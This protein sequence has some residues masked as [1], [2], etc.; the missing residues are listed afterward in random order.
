MNTYRFK[1]SLRCWHE[2]MAPAEICDLL[3]MEPAIRRRAGQER[4]TPRGNKAGGTLSSS[5]CSFELSEGNDAELSDEL[6]KWNGR[7]LGRSESIREF[8]KGG[9]RM[10]YFVGLFIDGNS[11]FEL[12]PEVAGSL[13]ELGIKLSLD[14]YP[15][16]VAD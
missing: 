2:T 1:L 11:G 15:P 14:I 3:G 13:A 12:E 7:L 9:G 5:Y 6:K 16:D 8:H 10:E 4:R